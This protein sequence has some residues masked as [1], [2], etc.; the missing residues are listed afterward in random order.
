MGKFTPRLLTIGLAL[1]AVAIASRGPALRKIVEPRRPRDGGTDRGAPGGRGRAG[2]RARDPVYCT[3]WWARDIEEAMKKPEFLP[4]AFDSFGYATTMV[5]GGITG[6]VLYM[7]FKSG[8]LLAG[9]NASN[10]GENTLFAF[11]VAFCGGLFHF[12]VQG[13]FESA[14]EKVV[15]KK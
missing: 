3:K 7:A 1:L 11:F 12:K 13:W 8:V 2:L 14:I 4:N 9:G 10:S 5:G 15:K 6:I